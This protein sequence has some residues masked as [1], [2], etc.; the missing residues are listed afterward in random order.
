MSNKKLNYVKES[1]IEKILKSCDWL[2]MLGERSNGKSY[3]AKNLIIRKC[4]ESGKEF[5]YLRRYDLDVKDSLCVNYFGD[6]PVEAITDGEY[7]CIDVYRKNIWLANIGDDGKAT[8]GK[9]IGYCHALSASEHYK[10]L[11]FPDVDY[12][13][14]EE[15]VSMDGRYLYNETQK[16]QQYTSTIFRNRKGKVILIGNTISRI[17]PYYRDWDLKVAKQKL[18]SVENY[19]FHNDNGEDTKMS[20]YLTD[21]LNYNSGMF[22]GL[23][24]KNITKGAYEVQEQAHLPKSYLKYNNLYTIVLE[25]N[26]FKFLCELLQDKEESNN[27]FWYVQPKTTDVKSGTRVISNKFSPDPYYSLSLRRPIN[28]NEKQVF[29]MFNKG[30]VC[31]SDNLTGT[32]FNNIISHMM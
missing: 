21:S 26:E 15:L 11:A 30:K 12:I 28:A 18:G 8:R 14:F 1:N 9:K 22:F 16:I 6:S 13:I 24:A 31:F 27:I 7:H 32:E 25:Y 5:I 10:S 2:M 4:I 3:A 19:V 17:C 23:A 20:V 29:D